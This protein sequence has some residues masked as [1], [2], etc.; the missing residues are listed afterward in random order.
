MWFISPWRSVGASCVKTQ[1]RVKVG[2]DPAPAAEKTRGGQIPARHKSAVAGAT[3]TVTWPGRRG[4]FPTLADL[5]RTRT[6]KDHASPERPRDG[7]KPQPPVT[8]P[9]ALT[10]KQTCLRRKRIMVSGHELAVINNKAAES[11]LRC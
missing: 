10:M 5:R 2:A 11:T 4:S 6:N 9:S 1:P 8:S 3:R 7:G